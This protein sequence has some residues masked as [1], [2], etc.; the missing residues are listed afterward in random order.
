MA[1]SMHSK[2]HQH[3]ISSRISMKRLAWNGNQHALKGQSACNQLEDLDEEARLEWQSACTQRAISMQSLAIRMHLK[4]R[5]HAIRGRQHAIRGR[6]HAIRGRQ[7]AISGVR[8]A[9]TRQW[10][11]DAVSSAHTSYVQS[12]TASP[13][14]TAADAHA[15]LDGLPIQ[16]GAAAA[17]VTALKP[18]EC[19]LE[20]ELIPSCTDAGRSGLPRGLISSDLL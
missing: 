2:G 3:A 1:I 5:Q 4:G 18:A 17:V 9:L 16:A 7:H 8:H 19:P 20:P 13:S 6:Q 15:T 14:S 10:P 12:S 11:L